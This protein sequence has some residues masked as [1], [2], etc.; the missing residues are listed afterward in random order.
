MIQRGNWQKEQERNGWIFGWFMPEGLAKDKRLEVKVASFP[1]GFSNNPHYQ[2]TATK[3]DLVIR[4]EVI[5]E[6]DGEDMKLVEG[7]Y[8]ILAPKTMSR[9]K[10][11]LSEDFQIQTLKFPS[12]ADDRVEIKEG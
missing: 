8:V 3:I 4:G 11:V 9:I 6:T 1:K 12:V 5:Y 2:K 10:E 7:D